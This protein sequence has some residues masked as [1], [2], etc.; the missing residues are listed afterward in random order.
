MLPITV[1]TVGDF[2]R[3]PFSD[4]GTKFSERLKHV[5]KMTHKVITDGDTEKLLAHVGKND[6]L[7]AL[8]ATGKAITSEAFATY[9]DGHINIGKP[10]T[11]L[12]GGPKGLPDGVKQRADKLL[13]L[14]PMTTTHDMAHLFLLEQLYRAFSIIRGSEYHY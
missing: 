4:L 12:I 8:E 6:T 5:A 7:V 11:F 9:I 2:P 3:G 13:S 1:I 10:I 14:S